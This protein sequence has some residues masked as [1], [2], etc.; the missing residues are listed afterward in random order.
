M[1]FFS[2]QY[3]QLRMLDQGL[4]IS[5]HQDY[6][7]YHQYTYPHQATNHHTNDHV[8]WEP[9]WD[10]PG[11][12]F[13]HHL[14]SIPED[15]T[16]YDDTLSGRYARME[17]DKEERKIFDTI[18]SLTVDRHESELCRVVG[19]AFSECLAYQ[20]ENDRRGSRQLIDDIEKQSNFRL[21]E[22][23]RVMNKTQYRMHRAF[24]E[25]YNVETTRTT[26]HGTSIATSTL[27]TATGFKGA[28]CQRGLFGRGVYSAPDV[29]QALSYAT[30]SSD[31]RQIVFAVDFLQGPSATG[32]PN[33]VC[34]RVSLL[35]CGLLVS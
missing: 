7:H 26:Y 8:A 34:I 16:E 33:Q 35:M 25:N 27:I 10:E 22:V 1:D 23:V 2:A 28:A 5:Q 13:D 24:A 19:T 14:P 21:E 15:V 30:P 31:A 17:V 32:S 29:W 12:T 11:L 18:T 9:Q 4:D 3:N 6:N 20:G